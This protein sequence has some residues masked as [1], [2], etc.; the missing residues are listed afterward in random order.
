MRNFRQKMSKKKLTKDGGGIKQSPFP[1]F[2][3]PS[4]NRKCVTNCHC[5]DCGTFFTMEW[6]LALQAQQFLGVQKVPMK[7]ESSRASFLLKRT[8]DVTPW[9]EKWRVRPILT[10]VCRVVDRV[11]SFHFVHFMIWLPLLLLF[12]PLFTSGKATPVNGW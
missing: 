7:S 5:H 3:P 6:T 10:Q 8:V 12:F 11:H 2:L 9:L 4:P 1:H